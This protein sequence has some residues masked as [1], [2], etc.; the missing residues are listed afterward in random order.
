MNLSK[1]AQFDDTLLNKI[2]GQYLAGFDEV[3]NGAIAGD[4]KSVV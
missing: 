3:A 1:L 4:R 2:D